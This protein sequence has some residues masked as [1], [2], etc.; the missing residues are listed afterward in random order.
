MLMSILS[1]FIIILFFILFVLPFGIGIRIGKKEEAT[2]YSVFVSSWQHIIGIEWN[3]EG[4]WQSVRLKIFN[5]AFLK[6]ASQRQPP[7]SKQNGQQSSA[8]KKNKNK[9][10]HMVCVIANSIVHSPKWILRLI[11]TFHLKA[12]EVR[13]D[14]SMHDPACTGAAYGLIQSLYLF[15]SSKVHLSVMPNFYKRKCEGSI[16]LEFQFLFSQLLGYLL[17]AG[18]R[19]LWILGRCHFKMKG[20]LAW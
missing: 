11:K 7:K 20:R 15:N 13:G 10:K 12:L 8:P 17:L 6:K 1:I 2:S 9:K 18:V 5:I 19:F 4:G 16:N 14:L 3:G